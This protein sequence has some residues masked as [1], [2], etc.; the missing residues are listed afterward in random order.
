MATSDPTDGSPSF[1]PELF[2]KFIDLFETDSTRDPALWN[3]SLVSRAWSHHSR[4]RIFSQVNFTSQDSFQQ[5]CKNTAPGPNGP[6]SLVRV[7][8]I[9]QMGSDIWIHPDILLEGE[10]HLASFTNLKGLVAFDLHTSFFNDRA[11]LSQCFRIMGQGL[12]FVRLHHVKGTPQTL[13]PFI[14]QFPATKT[15]DIEYY[16]ETGDTS[17]EEPVDET[18]GQFKGSLRLLS[19]DPDDPDG[20]G[21]I[22]SIARLPLEYEGVSLTS[23]LD[24]I[25]PYNRLIL[26][27]APTLERIRIIDT[28]DP[29]SHWESPVGV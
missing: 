22:D 24:F 9:S 16:V 26:A 4:K 2:E 17:P 21:L 20:S 13:I 18:K 15:L 1:P 12:D 8:V 27:C 25:E 11:L 5:W 23:A 10:Q 28:R 3:L 19:I 7:L 14:Q 6:S 29:L